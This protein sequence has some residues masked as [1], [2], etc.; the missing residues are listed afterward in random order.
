MACNAGELGAYPLEV[1]A[2]SFGAAMQQ[3]QIA[4]A[5]PWFV[6]RVEFAPIYTHGSP[7]ALPLDCSP[8]GRKGY[9]A[10]VR[11]PPMLTYDPRSQEQARG[12]PGSGLSAS[13]AANV[14]AFDW[15]ELQLKN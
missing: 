10:E 2:G 7:G 9:S 15:D 3:K 5:S 14:N 11:A 13:A 1:T 6:R 12:Q 4:V 8:G